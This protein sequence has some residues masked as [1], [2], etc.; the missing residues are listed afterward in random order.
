[1]LLDVSPEPARGSLLL[2]AF[3]VV[4][5][6]VALVMGFV[7]LLIRRKRRSSDHRGGTAQPSNPNQP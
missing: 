3:L 2:L 5:L 1:M 7:L 4:G 6:V